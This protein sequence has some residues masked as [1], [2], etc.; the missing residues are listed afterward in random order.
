AERDRLQRILATPAVGARF[1]EDRL[2]QMAAAGPLSPAA[3]SE[4]I[5]A[6]TAWEAARSGD[7][8]AMFALQLVEAPGG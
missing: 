7:D 4:R 8:R 3:M 6:A 5:D 2:G 1:G